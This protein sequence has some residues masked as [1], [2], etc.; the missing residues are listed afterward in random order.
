M[1]EAWQDS[2]PKVQGTSSLR[3]RFYKVTLPLLYVGIS[4][5]A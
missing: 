1:Y 5:K 4:P 2:E 3:S